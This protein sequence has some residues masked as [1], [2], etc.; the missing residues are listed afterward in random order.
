VSCKQI[1]DAQ[2]SY[3]SGTYSVDP[4]GSGSPFVAFCDMVRDG[5]GYTMF[6]ATTTNSGAS[7]SRPY[8]NDPSSDCVRHL[9]LSIA[10]DA[11]VIASCGDMTAAGA[12]TT[13]FKFNPDGFAFDYMQN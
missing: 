7:F 6:F 9:P 3:G 2:S 5:G 10:R 1:L 8:C 11:D 12:T 13:A 4:D